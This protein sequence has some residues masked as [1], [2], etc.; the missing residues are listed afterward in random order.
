M[1]DS[2]IADYQGGFRLARGCQEQLFVFR[3]VL[4]LATK[5][6]QTLYIAYLDQKKAFDSVQHLAIAEAYAK[7]GASR[8]TVKLMKCLFE[9]RKMMLGDF[10]IM[11][12]SGVPQ[13]GILSPFSYICCINELLT[14]NEIELLGY[15]VSDDV[16]V[17]ITQYADD[18]LLLSDNPKKLQEIIEL[19]VTRL[20]YLG[21]EMAPEKCGVQIF[22]PIHEKK[23]PIFKIKD[24]PV[25]YK[26]MESLLGI[27][28]IPRTGSS[29]KFLRRGKGGHDVIAMLRSANS[30]KLKLPLHELKKFAI[31][32][33]IPASLYG[34][35][36]YGIYEDSS[37]CWTQAMRSILELPWHS[38]YNK[39][40][41][42]EF[43]GVLLPKHIIMTRTLK[44]AVKSMKHQS[45]MVREI[46]WSSKNSSLPWYE[47]IIEIARTLDIAESFWELETLSREDITYAVWES[48]VKLFNRNAKAS[49][50]RI[51]KR[52]YAVALNISEEDVAPIPNGLP[53]CAHDTFGIAKF[54]FYLRYIP[55]KTKPHLQRNC[56]MCLDRV[57]KD[58]PDH[59]IS[60]SG[61]NLEDDRK[62][63]KLRY[64]QDVLNIAIT[65][66]PV[67]LLPSPD[68]WIHFTNR[69]WDDDMRMNIQKAAKILWRLRVSTKIS[70]EPLHV[71]E[72][73]EDQVDVQRVKRKVVRRPLSE[74]LRL[75]IMYREAKSS[76]EREKV[77]LENSVALQTMRRWY[78]EMKHKLPA[79][80]CSNDG[81]VKVSL[82]SK[83]VWNSVERR[84]MVSEYW[85]KKKR[86]GI[87]YSVRLHLEY[88]MTE[89]GYSIS[90]AQF[91]EWK[92][93]YV[94]N[95]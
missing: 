76:I 92:K 46:Y 95:V 26:S 32:T 36:I 25:P 73:H 47:N 16:Y 2:I 7:S 59:W 81:M 91:N 44:L 90:I 18:L 15:K 8:S 27:H 70:L 68:K 66:L 1:V 23:R 3:N 33:V 71:P 22:G 30:L 64:A 72:V 75:L 82:K 74:R 69:S 80:L 55:R 14:T 77:L 39:M 51:V 35:E 37:A 86:L 34:S 6:N 20:Q 54:I 10:K 65:Y 67:N 50:I 57:S 11:Q 94:Q 48:S 43:L 61:H 29:T 58:T 40:A 93:L 5:N 79:H 52:E 21:G 49:V 84:K 38:S 4:D 9:N 63:S 19:V 89:Y 83:H 87:K 28:F 60:C 78:C 56:P 85:E 88:W 62:L 31:A 53:I 42:A 24:D 45:L 41:M 17:A 13:G 12:N